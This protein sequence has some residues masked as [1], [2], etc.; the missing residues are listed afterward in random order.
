MKQQFVHGEVRH[1]YEENEAATC[2]RGDPL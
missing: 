1:L 2:L